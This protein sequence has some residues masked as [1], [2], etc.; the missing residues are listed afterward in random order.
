MLEMDKKNTPIYIFLG[1]FKAFDTLN[2]EILLQKLKY[3]SITGITLNLMESYMTNRKQ[4]VIIDDI[5]SER[6]PMKTGIPQGSIL[7][8]LLF[9]IYINDIAN[10]SDL[11]SF[12]VYADD[13]TLSTTLEIVLNRRKHESI[14]DKINKEL[15]NI[16]VWLKCNR[17]SLN[18]SKCT[19][20]IFHTH[21]R[22]I[23]PSYLKINDNVVDRV[24]EFNF[25]GLTLDE[26]L[27]WK[28]HIN[29]ISNK[30]SK[31][32]GVLNKLKYCLPINAKRLI[33]N[34]N[35][36]SSKLLCSHLGI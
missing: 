27:N 18:I 24:K 32:M 23:N 21:Q 28:S 33:Y 36:F 29:I 3:Y 16:N 31:S 17:L 20:I 25:I 13:T 19:Y 8:P 15:I 26:N 2:H 12:V 9:I 10:S 34:S 7:G 14:D 30:I 1:L 6:L 11:F 4:F 5:K 22:K 35:T